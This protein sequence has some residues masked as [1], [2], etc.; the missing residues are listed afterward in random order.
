M[1]KLNDEF[2]EMQFF[3]NVMSLDYGWHSGWLSF[4]VFRTRIHYNY[5]LIVVF[6][7]YYDRLMMEVVLKP[8]NIL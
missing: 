5:N 2:I 1:R 8:S 6:F 3:V 4:E 7:Y